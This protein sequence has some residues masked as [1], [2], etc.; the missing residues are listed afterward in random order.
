MQV[1][2]DLLVGSVFLKYEFPFQRI[3]F[4][5]FSI[6]GAVQISKSLFLFIQLHF[7]H[8]LLA[9]SPCVECFRV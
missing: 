1:E 7:K 3:Q 5:L 6:E 2:P 9:F 8:Q 4:L